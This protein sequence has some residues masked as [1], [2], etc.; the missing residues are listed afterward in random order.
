[1]K[2]DELLLKI[3]RKRY[4]N[5]QA[6]VAQSRLALDQA[7]EKL[8]QAEKA[9]ERFDTHRRGKINDIYNSLIGKEILRSKLDEAR[10]IERALN[11]RLA[12][13]KVGANDCADQVKKKRELLAAAQLYLMDCHKGLEKAKEVHA[14]FV[15]EN[16]RAEAL[17]NDEIIDEFA[18][19]MKF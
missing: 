2:M 11:E 7:R 14:E 5:A 9:V 1:M 18:G 17:R 8:Y 10:G 12:A 13:M 15:N 19:R 4:E 6:D 16:L 3:R